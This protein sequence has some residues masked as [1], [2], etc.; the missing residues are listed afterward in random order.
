MAALDIRG[1]V[2]QMLFLTAN[3]FAIDGEDVEAAL[4]RHGLV[5]RQPA[6]EEDAEF[7]QDYDIQIG[8]LILVRTPELK[9]YLEAE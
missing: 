2:R 8:D 5:H 3:D 7:I 6:T 1:F 4:L 9:A